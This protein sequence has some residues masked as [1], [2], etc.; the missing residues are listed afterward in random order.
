M[1]RDQKVEPHSPVGK[2]DSQGRIT[3]DLTIP[4]AELKLDSVLGEGAYGTVYRGRWKSSEVAIKKLKV[5]KFSA[6]ALEEF[7]QEAQ[8]MF[9]LGNESDHIVRLKKIC[10]ES[11]NYSL[12]MELMPQGSLYNVLHNNQELPWPIRY[13]I[14]LD[15]AHGLETL[16]EHQIL[17]RDLKSLNVLLGAGLR[18]K[19]SDFGLSKIKQETSSQSSQAAKG[20][21]QWMAP[22]LFDDEPQVTKA[23]DIYSLG[24]VYWE[25]ASRAIPFAKAPNQQVVLG[26]IM[27][28]KKETIPADCPGRVFSPATAKALL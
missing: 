24:M 3:L 11:P 13:Q 9:Q 4:Y 10:L 1:Q 8:I 15:I 2:L 20:T 26:W 18:A 12:V 16:H 25:L 22:E 19:L 5:Q 7:R 21:P 6:A 14:A 28:G 23:S 17:H 27:R